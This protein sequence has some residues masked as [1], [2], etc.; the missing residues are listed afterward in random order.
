MGD[1]PVAVVETPVVRSTRENL[2]AAIRGEVCERDQMYPAFLQQARAAGN[3]AAPHLPSGVAGRGGTRRLYTE[4]L[5]GASALSI[6][7]ISRR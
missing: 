2:E 6:A 4:A 1:I 5:E 7:G 3:H